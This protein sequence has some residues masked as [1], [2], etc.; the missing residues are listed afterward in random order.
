MRYFVYAI[1]LLSTLLFL[2]H[3]VLSIVAEKRRGRKG[4]IVYTLKQF[5]LFGVA[6]GL[7]VISDSLILDVLYSILPEFIRFSG[8]RDL[9]LVLMFPL[10]LFIVCWIL[11]PTKDLPL[12]KRSS[13]KNN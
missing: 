1:W 8:L 10:F 7:S 9:L 4:N 3:T 6:I 11:G 12:P 2:Y 13:R 5:L